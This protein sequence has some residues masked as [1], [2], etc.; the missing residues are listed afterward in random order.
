MKRKKINP[1]K[2]KRFIENNFPPYN[3]ITILEETNERVI[4]LLD[5]G[6]REEKLKVTIGYSGEDYNLYKLLETDFIK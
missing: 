1:K 3:E 5:Y 6:K 2:V 4:A